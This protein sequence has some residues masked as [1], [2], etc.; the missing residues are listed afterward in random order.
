MSASFSYP[1]EDDVP[2]FERQPIVLHFGSRF[3]RLGFSGV[4]FPLKTV[5]APLLD[6]N[7]PPE[8]PLLRSECANVA[9]EEEIKAAPNAGPAEGFV[10]KESRRFERSL[11]Q[12]LPTPAILSHRL[13][14]W[15]QQILGGTFGVNTNSGDCVVVIAEGPLLQPEIKAAIIRLLMDHFQVRSRNKRH[16]LDC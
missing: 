1:D 16:M 6:D 9:E 11:W 5:V 8:F 2:L 14:E 15:L 4:H 12:E 7:K 3:C 10:K 13:G